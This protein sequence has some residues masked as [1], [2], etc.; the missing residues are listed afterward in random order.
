MGLIYTHIYIRLTKFIPTAGRL[1]AVPFR[2]PSGIR[3]LSFRRAGKV[4][5]RFRDSLETILAPFL[6]AGEKNIP[7][8][9]GA[10]KWPRAPNHHNRVE[11]FWYPSGLTSLR[12]CIGFCVSRTHV[13]RTMEGRLEG[14]LPGRVTD[15]CYPSGI[16]P[17]SFPRAGK[18]ACP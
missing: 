6:Y 10:P 18:V 5:I 4:A 2:Y 13:R 7:Q 15:V 11:S 14:L 16:L 17:V 1:F 8:L 3:P 12:S 9:K